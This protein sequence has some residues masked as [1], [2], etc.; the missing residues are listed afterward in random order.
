M[1]A[2]EW[3]RFWLGKKE[4]KVMEM[5]VHKRTGTTEP[6]TCKRWWKVRLRGW[7]IEATSKKPLNV[8]RS[9]DFIGMGNHQNL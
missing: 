7:V 1:D 9:L 5:R 6:G 8:V 4:K 3:M 2:E